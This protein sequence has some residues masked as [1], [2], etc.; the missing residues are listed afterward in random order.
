[1]SAM[2]YVDRNLVPGESVEYRAR[3]HWIVFAGPL[4]AALLGFGAIVDGVGARDGQW[5]LGLG[6]ATLAVAS[7]LTLTRWFV[8]ATSEFAVTNKRV[9][10]K[11][12]ILSRHSLEILLT[13]VEG[14]GVDQRLLG[15]M[16]GYGTIVVTGTG[17]TREAF[18]RIAQ[19]LRFRREVQS[20]VPA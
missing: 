8:F 20:R 9:L 1:M 3:L 4:V 2:G 5:M 17:G 11:V 14:I 19:P 10:I 7:V 18:E 16:L 12:G 6:L 13:K 15:R